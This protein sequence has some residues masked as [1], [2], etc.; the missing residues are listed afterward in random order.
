MKI[1]ARVLHS[2]LTKEFG[3]RHLLFVFSGRRGF[4]CWI[5]DRAARELSAEARRAI[6]DYF[7]LITGGMSMVKRVTLNPKQKIH[8]MVTKALVEIDKDFDD[9]MV[10]KQDFLG[11]DHLMQSVL[12]LCT[13]DNLQA[14]LSECKHR[15]RSTSDRWKLMQITCRSF[16]SNK[17]NYLIEEIK[18]QHCF[19]RIDAHVTKGLNHLLKL[20]FCIH[21][22]TGN[23]CVPINLDTIDDFDL[24]AV[25][26]IKNM[27]RGSLDPYLKTM[28]NFVDSLVDA[29]GK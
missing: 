12:D 4:H 13:D 14:K 11:T 21:P 19:P 5:A 15:A 26:N 24:L 16:K 22:K 7:S 8:P 20:P 18:L 29:S 23:V 10:E 6:G 1:G 9:L 28:K 3:F 17:K 25:P 2:I 27:T